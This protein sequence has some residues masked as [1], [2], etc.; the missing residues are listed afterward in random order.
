MT[1]YGHTSSTRSNHRAMQVSAHLYGRGIKADQFKDMHPT[2]RDTHALQAGM[3]RP[4]SGQ[5]WDLVHRGLQISEENDQRFKSA[6]QGGGGEDPF[7][8]L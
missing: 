5:E 6:D 1:E 4:L 7:A 3:T 8:G 2:E